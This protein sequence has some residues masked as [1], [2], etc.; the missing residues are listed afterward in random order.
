MIKKKDSDFAESIIENDS[1]FQN[2]IKKYICWPD[3]AFL[4]YM[5]KTNGYNYIN[6]TQLENLSCLDKIKIC[7]DYVDE[8]GDKINYNPH[9]ELKNK[10]PVYIEMDGWKNFDFSYVRSFNDLHPN[11]KKFLHFLEN[12]VGVP[13]KYIDI[14]NMFTI[15]E[16]SDL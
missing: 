3:I 1:E 5:A 2:G 16:N 15:I 6:M 11:I 12:K 7:I 9:Y 14:K 13:I 4:N 10:K 8:N